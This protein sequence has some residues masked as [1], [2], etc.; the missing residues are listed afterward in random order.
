G[1][2][3]GTVLLW[4]SY[5]VTFMMLVTGFAGFFLGV[6]SSGLIALAPLLYS[7]AIRS[8]GVGWAMRL[9]R[10]GSF[11]RTACHHPARQSG[12][13]DRRLLCRTRDGRAVRGSVH[14][15]DRH[16][17]VLRGRQSRSRYCGDRRGALTG[18]TSTKGLVL[19]IL[20]LHDENASRISP[21]CSA[22][23]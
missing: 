6:T 14:E 2:V 11:F 19:A 12:L 22:R 17:P 18:L 20:H 16:Q 3:G 13:A 23:R 21:I 5:F 10:L 4:V 9:G 1:M 15:R 8:T 7:T